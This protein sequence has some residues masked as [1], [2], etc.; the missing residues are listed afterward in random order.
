MARYCRLLAFNGGSIYI[1]SIL[2][3][4]VYIVFKSGGLS[5]SKYIIYIIYLRRSHSNVCSYMYILVV[6]HSYLFD[7]IVSG[8][9]FI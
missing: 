1:V 4:E 6:D 5:I 7:R 8:E 2:Q 9:V 3:G